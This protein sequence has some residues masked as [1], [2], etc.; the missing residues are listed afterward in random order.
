MQT[1]PL[2]SPTAGVEVPPERDTDAIQVT[3]RFDIETED[4]E[5]LA[6]S[7][8]APAGAPK[9]AVQI[10][11]GMGM[12]RQSYRH[13]A[14]YLAARGYAVLSFDPRAMGESRRGP[15]R[16]EKAR[17]TDWARKDNPAA[18]EWLA[19]RYPTVPKFAVGHSFGGQIT[20]LMPNHELL[21]GLVLVFAPKGQVYVAS[22][23]GMLQGLLLMGIY[24]PLTIPLFGYAPVR[25]V[26][27]GQDL[28]AGVAWDWI[29]WTC[30]FRWIEGIFRPEEMYHDKIKAPILALALEGDPLASPENCRRL[31]R[32]HYCGAESELITFR[33]VD[34][35]KRL[36]HVGY[37]KRQFAESHWV[38][39]AEWLDRRVAEVPA[40]QPLRPLTA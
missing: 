16:G 38:R 4:G 2:R 36:T 25:L 11:G 8:H 13:F 34:A 9:A 24:M 20:G 29:R 22:P 39:V 15:L 18:L 19:R 23:N 7:L 10:N 28:P 14:S 31:L 21:S 3:D 12:K 27:N 33:G 32:E 30:H 5:Q 6:A 40:A 35:P 1:V 26:M 37:F 17:L